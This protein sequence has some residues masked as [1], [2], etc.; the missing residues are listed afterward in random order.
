MPTVG[1]LLLMQKGVVAELT[2]LLGINS[3]AERRFT[4]VNKSTF[5]LSTL[6]RQRAGKN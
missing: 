5:Y 6:I 3:P 4:A 1:E 2:E